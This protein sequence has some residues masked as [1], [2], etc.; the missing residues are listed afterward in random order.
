MISPK[1]SLFVVAF[2]LFSTVGIC[3][4]VKKNIPPVLHPKIGTEATSSDGKLKIKL[5]GKK[6]NFGG[7]AETRDEAIHSPKSVNVHPSGKKFYVNSLE[8]GTTVVYDMDGFK[9]LKIISHHIDESHASLWSEPSELYPFTHYAKNNIFMG[10]PVEAAFS[11][12]GRY[13]WVPYYR[14]SYDINA[15]DPSAVAIID[16]ET[17][18][19]VRL[20]ETGPLPKMIATSHDGKLVAISHWGNNTVGLI[21]ISSDNPRDWHHKACLVVDYVLPLHYS[22]TVSADR[23]N[24]S[25]YALRGTVFTPD[26]RYLLVG[27]MG[28]GGGI[29]IIDVKTGQYLGRVLGMMSNVRHLV[30]RDG[31]LYL[32]I[33]GG[34][35][36]QRIRLKKFLDSATAMSGKTT[37]VSGWENCKVGTGAR[38]IE[39]SPSGR[40]VFA[41]CNNASQVCIVDT[42]QMK[43]VA[44]ISCD[45]Y[46]VGLDISKDGRYVFVTSQ[47]R[48]DRGGNAVNIYE[49]EYAEPEEAADEI[50]VVANDETEQNR[51]VNHDTDTEKK[52]W[53]LP[54]LVGGGVMLLSCGALYKKYK[55]KKT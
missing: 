4:T 42:R 3:Q 45:S 11:H 6:Q 23:D 2:V 40:Y 39:L 43:Q 49:V 27:C 51:G 5:V 25:G 10:K 15:Q 53:L 37:Y 22:L 17:D 28:G 55:N 14:R 24:G 16:T 29:A 12:A 19:I 36:V 52:D 21:D 34:G 20:M 13:L 44:A 7:S 47:G 33:N 1:Y 41:A 46:P 30:I 8:G 32:S 38:T 9:R 54:C 48:V 26:D 18:E 31:W 35:Y 50:D